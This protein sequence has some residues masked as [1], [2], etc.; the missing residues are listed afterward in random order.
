VTRDERS[1]EE[2][3]D[4]RW[5]G[6]L[7]SLL[8]GIPWSEVSERVDTLRFNAP[9]SGGLRVRN[10][11]GRVEVEGE[12]RDDIIV[13][14]AKRARAESEE[15][16]ARLL[17]AIGL[18]REEQPQGLFLEVE[19]PR[20]WNRHGHVNLELRVPR[21]LRIAC[22]SV[23]GKVSVSGMRADVAARSSNGP[24]SVEDV[25]GDV[26]AATTN[27]KVICVGTSGRLMA[28]SSNG[29]IEISEHRG[30]VDASTSNGLIRA[31]LEELG[32]AGVLLATSNGRIVLEIPRDANA[33]VDVRVDNGVIRH[34]IELGDATRSTDG[35]LRGRLGQGGAVIKL[36]TSNGSITLR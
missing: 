14:V 2:A 3:Q 5:G 29:K 35:R 4:G 10:P 16:A 33:D 1:D 15:E 13:E 26:Q 19:I 25:T 6:F 27:N 28:R 12:D 9:R 20:R 21:D 24:V 18:R 36:R 7:R 11:N 31:A 22:E 32:P 34:E 17:E 30:D 23:N 8:S